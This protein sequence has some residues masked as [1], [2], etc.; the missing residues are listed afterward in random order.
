MRG[1]D[2]AVENLKLVEKIKI[3]E[4]VK[5]AASLKGAVEA[6]AQDEPAEELCI[7]TS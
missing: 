1:I 4:S 3:A 6:A 5:T 7:L 2:M